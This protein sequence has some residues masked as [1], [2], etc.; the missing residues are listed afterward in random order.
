[1]R[2]GPLVALAVIALCLQPAATR[3][4]DILGAGSTF[5]APVLSKWSADYSA[6]GGDAVSYQR[7]GERHDR[8]VIEINVFPVLLFDAASNRAEIRMRLGDGNP[9][10]EAAEASPIMRCAA[11]KLRFT[12]A[13][14]PC[15]DAVRKIEP[16]RH[17]SNHGIDCSFHR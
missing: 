8:R 14:N 11:G 13:R 15:G 5:V 9:L 12:P 2:V 10:A 6:R 3:A 1:M 17:H 7:I 4:D 16:L